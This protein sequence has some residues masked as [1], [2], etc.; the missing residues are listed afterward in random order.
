MEQE[1]VYNF[2]K[3]VGWVPSVEAHWSMEYE[4]KR[5]GKFKVTLIDRKPVLGEYF[6]TLSLS[7]DN[8]DGSLNFE[9]AWA[10][11]RHDMEYR[12]LDMGG[13]MEPRET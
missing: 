10:A 9:S 12:P 6:Y 7:H 11:I 4:T 1:P 8:P 13:R 5:L 2:V 3:G